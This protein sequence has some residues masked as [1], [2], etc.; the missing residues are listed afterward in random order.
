[1]NTCEG[2]EG[3]RNQRSVFLL[4]PLLY[5]LSLLSRSRLLSGALFP[6]R[7]EEGRFVGGKERER[8]V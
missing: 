7:R 3:E 6:W 1:M 5:H 8:W 4:L 2:E